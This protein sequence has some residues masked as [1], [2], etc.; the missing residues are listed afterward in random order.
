MDTT[1]L[2]V[3]FF[4]LSRR[5]KFAMTIIVVMVSVMFVVLIV[6]ISA[7]GGNSGPGCATNGTAD[8]RAI[9]STNFI[10]HGG[11]NGTTHTAP[12]SGVQGAVS[13]DTAEWYCCQN[14]GE[15]QCFGFHIVILQQSHL[16]GR[17]GYGLPPEDS[18]NSLPTRADTVFIIRRKI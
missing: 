12:D 9:P 4:G 18:K 6:V 10:A 17:Q 7:I 14:H 13:G 11:S 8:N 16:C 1:G 15:N 5:A 2:A 3:T